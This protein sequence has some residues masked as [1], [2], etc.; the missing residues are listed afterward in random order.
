MSPHG[1]MR[2]VVLPATYPLAMVIIAGLLFMLQDGLNLG[3]M[4]KGQFNADRSSDD[5]PTDEGA[6]K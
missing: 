6:S 5:R 4:V 2:R 1:F 3:G